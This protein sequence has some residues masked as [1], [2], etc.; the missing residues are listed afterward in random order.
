MD[1]P[2]IDQRLTELSRIDRENEYLRRRLLDMAGW[3]EEAVTELVAC[4]RRVA[5]VEDHA[6]LVQAELDAIRRTR[7]WRVLAPLRMA[8]GRVRRTRTRS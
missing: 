2:D 8:Y 6:R 4:E 1:E 5:E 3:M 7:T